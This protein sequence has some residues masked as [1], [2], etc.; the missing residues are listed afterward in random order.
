MFQLTIKLRIASYMA[1]IAVFF[2]AFM[3]LFFPPQASKM[4]NRLMTDSAVTIASLFA[5]NIEPAYDALGFGGEEIIATALRNLAGDAASP[6]A[7]DDANVRTT[8]CTPDRD[9][10]HRL[11]RDGRAARQLQRPGLADRVV[12]ARAPADRA[13]RRRGSPARDRRP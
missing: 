7:P 3:V 12:G 10:H 6:G 8:Q 11:Q 1:L 13:P 5:S 4:G 2:T 9:Q